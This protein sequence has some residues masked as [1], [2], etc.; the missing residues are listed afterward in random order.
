MSENV[1]V[2]RTKEETLP[3]TVGEFEEELI[4]MGATIEHPYTIPVDPVARID[5]KIVAFWCK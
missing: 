4:E 5:G 2:T 3:L 1:S